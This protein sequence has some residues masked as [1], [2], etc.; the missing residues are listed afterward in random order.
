MT[1]ESVTIREFSFPN[2]YA[3]IL[4]LWE[5]ME[6]GI[7]V[8]ISDTPGEIQKKLERDPDLFLVAEINDQIIGTAIGAFDGRRGLIYHLAVHKEKRSKGIAKSLLNEVEKRLKAKGCIK[9]LMVAFKDNIPA[10]Q[11][12]KSQGWHHVEEDIVFAKELV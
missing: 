7:N 3:E 6:S 10:I 1:T 5:S 9:V 12:Y 11:L 2:D 4:K 8:G